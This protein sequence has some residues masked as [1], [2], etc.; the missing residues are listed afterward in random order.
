MLIVENLKNTK[1]HNPESDL[2]SCYLMIITLAAF[3]AFSRSLGHIERES[4]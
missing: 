2:Y 3:D 1:K 4:Q